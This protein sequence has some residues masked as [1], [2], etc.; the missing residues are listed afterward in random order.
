MIPI[1]T[2][3]VV[4]RFLEDTSVIT[5]LAYVIGRLPLLPRLFRDKKSKRDLIAPAIVFG[6]A[7][8]TE[9]LFP[10]ER[11]P[12][13]IFT[14]MSSF[15]GYSGGIRLGLATSTIMILLAAVGRVAQCC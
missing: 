7:G 3:E 2:H 6:L 9:M 15:A 14:L 10:G 1:V 11:Y 8:A 4:N 5:A 12:Y 13:V